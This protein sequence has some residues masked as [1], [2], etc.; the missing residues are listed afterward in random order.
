MGPFFFF[1]FVNSA[2]NV[3]VASR[4]SIRKVKLLNSG[5]QCS[6]NRR[7]RMELIIGEFLGPEDNLFS[8]IAYSCSSQAII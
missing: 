3:E 6:V 7:N 2:S 1:S 8:T 4:P 5:C